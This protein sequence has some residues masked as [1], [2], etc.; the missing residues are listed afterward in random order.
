MSIDLKKATKKEIEAHIRSLE[1]KIKLFEF[2]GKEA[3]EKPF[4]AV[5]I[6]TIG[7]VYHCVKVKFDLTD[8]F[9]KFEYTQGRHMAEFKA[10]EILNLQI[11]KS[12]QGT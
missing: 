9:E 10:K 11:S 4:E 7:G 3:Q 1:Q 8:I 5:S 6:L 2:E 12:K